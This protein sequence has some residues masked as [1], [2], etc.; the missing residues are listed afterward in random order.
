MPSTTNVTSSNRKKRRKYTPEFKANA[1][2]LAMGGDTTIAAVARDLGISEKSLY[3]WV[4]S[5]KQ[6]AAGGL[7]FE[8]RE[9]L[10]RLRREVRRLR[11]ER[12]ILKK[13]SILFAKGDS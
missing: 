8:E 13:A 5:A 6:E 2:K 12:D 9:E 10:S 7:T 11:Q 1:V 3:Q 4:S